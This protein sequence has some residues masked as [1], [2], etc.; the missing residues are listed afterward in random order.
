MNCK[1]MKRLKEFLTV[2]VLCLPLFALAQEETEPMPPDAKAREKIEAARIALITERLGLT[3]DQAEK[4]W[5]IYREFSGKQGEIRKELR[6]ARQ[7]LKPGNP[8]PEKEKQLVNL[9]LQLK[10]RE[11]D[12]EKDYSSRMLNVISAQQMLNL[13]NAERE[14]QRLIINQLQQRRLQQQRKETLRDRNQ[15]LRQKRQ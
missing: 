6:D 15:Q 11:L 4:F 5:P 13:R 2:A 8:D 1:T 9:G 12:L 10:Q 3:P 14:F 7:Q